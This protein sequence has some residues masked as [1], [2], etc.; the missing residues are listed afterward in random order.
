MT[1]CV[2]NTNVVDFLE[3]TNFR[4]PLYIIT[5]L[6]MVE[7]ASVTTVNNKGRRIYAQLG[8]DGTPAAVPVTVGPEV[9]RNIEESE[10]ASFKNSSL[11]IF[12]F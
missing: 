9:E 10:I 5:G 4:K 6:K 2:K 11:V 1:A 8:F 7:G 12:A 3:Q